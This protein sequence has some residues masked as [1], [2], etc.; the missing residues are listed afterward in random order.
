[1]E[2]EGPRGPWHSKDF[3]RFEYLPGHG[4]D[5]TSEVFRDLRGLISLSTFLISLK[6][7]FIPGFSHLPMLY[8]FS[9]HIAR[10]LS[11]CRG[12]ALAVALAG[13]VALA[14]AQGRAPTGLR[15]YHRDQYETKL[16][17]GLQNGFKATCS[18]YCLCSTDRVS[19]SMPLCGGR[20]RWRNPS[21]RH[22]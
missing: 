17:K 9:V 6:V 5:S 16:L 14:E 15:R 11:F 22:C 18:S 12:Q 21:F 8:Y 4:L 2:A 20:R 13:A 19:V 10:F 1:M 7:S 3:R